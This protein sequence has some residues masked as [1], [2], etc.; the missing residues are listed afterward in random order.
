MV[1]ELAFLGREQRTA[2]VYADTEVEAWVLRHE[3]FEALA[4]AT[5]RPPPC[6]WPRCCGS[7]PGSPGG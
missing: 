5:R 7:W 1:G 2:D 6:S 4:T 3:A